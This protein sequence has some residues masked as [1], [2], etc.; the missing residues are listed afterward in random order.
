MKFPNFKGPSDEIRVYGLFGFPLGHSLSAEMHNAAFR[1]LG[2]AAIYLPFERS[3][4]QF[5]KLACSKKRMI[6]DGFNLTI[7]HKE[8]IL[9][10]LNQIDPAAKLAGAVN[11]VKRDGNRWTGWNTDVFGFL[12]GLRESKFHA[13]GKK[14][15]ILGAGGAARAV[16]VALL[17]SGVREIAVI[18]RT[19]SRGKSLARE[20]QKKFR[21]AAIR[22]A[23]KTRLKQ[24]LAN[25][26][27]L[28]NSTSVG[29]KAGERGLLSKSDFPKR[30]IL[31]YDLI[32]HKKTPLLKLAGRL[33][34]R[35]QS[36]ETMLLMQGVKAFEIWTGK[37][38]PVNVMRKALKDAIRTA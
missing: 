7:P 21:K 16:M 30:K 4:K 10:Y 3:S 23:A 36:G 18:N 31:V 25:T 27:L 2:M 24:E 5:L 35:V 14:A 22:N 17:K 20:F 6:L 37:R 29:L 13:R 8:S 11:T 1:A 12:A 28:V 9:P 33:G 15:V 34:H 32:Y 26:D 19:Q 38:A